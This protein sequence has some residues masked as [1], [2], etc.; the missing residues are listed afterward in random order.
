MLEGIKLFAMAQNSVN[1]DSET[2]ASNL[3]NEEFWDRIVAGMD[4]DNLAPEDQRTINHFRDR[5]EKQFGT[6]NP[7]D[8]FREVLEE[9]GLGELGVTFGQPR[10]AESRDA[11]LGATFGTA[12]I[13]FGGWRLLSPWANRGQRLGG[14][15]MA[16]VGAAGGGSVV[17][18][19]REA[20][21]ASAGYLLGM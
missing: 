7:I 14:M 5:Y 18:S 16:G 2:I 19:R 8:D 12:A 4:Y 11:T 3:D 1:S 6:S 10:F 17:W 9:S 13:A 15:L 20:L 21:G